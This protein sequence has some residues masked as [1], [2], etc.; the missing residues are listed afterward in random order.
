MSQPLTIRC[1]CG[2]LE[3]AVTDPPWLNRAICYC[4]SCQA[5]PERL[6]KV[7]EVLDKQGGSDIVQT[8]PSALAF[9]RGRE[10]LACL[11]MT[12]KGPLRWYADCCNTPIGNTG[13]TPKLAFIGLLHSCLGGHQALDA[14]C[15]PPRAIVHVDGAVGEPK[16]RKKLPPGV[17]L[18][19]A[20]RLL[21]ARLDGS[22][23]RNPLFDDQGQPLARPEPPLTDSP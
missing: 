20:G 6:G 7:D 9:T 14:A 15:G 4:R 11:R 8:A 10:H 22:W 23:K 3:G 16:P 12:S 21:K 19:L 17:I 18:G 13:G 1:A 5:F 2:A